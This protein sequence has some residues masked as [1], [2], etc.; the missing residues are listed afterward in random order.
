MTNK[1]TFNFFS[2][3]FRNKNNRITFDISVVIFQA[4]TLIAIGII[5]SGIQDTCDPA[6]ALL[7]DH[8]NSDRT[9]MRIGSIFGLGLAY[10]NSKRLAV[11]K[12]EDGGVVFE[13]KKL[14]SDTKPSATPEVIFDHLL[15]YTDKK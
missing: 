13:L 2:K 14:L 3:I 6:A 1:T 4:G 5:S 12:K 8:I 10:A 11:L 9:V 15:F 7:M